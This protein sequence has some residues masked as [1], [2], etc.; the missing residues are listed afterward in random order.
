MERTCRS[1]PNCN[2]LKADEQGTV[3]CLL[4]VDK[5]EVVLVVRINYQFRNLAEG[6]HR[7]KQHA[8]DRLQSLARQF[9]RIQEVKVTVSAQRNWRTVDLTVDLGGALLR[10]EERS[11]EA[12]TSFDKALD[13]L[14]RQLQRFKERTRDF[15]RE[16]LRTLAAGEDPRKLLATEPTEEASDDREGVQIVR[17][18]IHPLKPMTPQEACLQMELLGHD[19]FV[20]VN[21][22]TQ[23]VGVVYRRR[24]GGYGLIEP[25]VSS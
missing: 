14:E 2:C 9:E 11:D 10:A 19:F 17:T 13:R 1:I 6:E 15:P 23:G 25:E 7:F 16:S 3:R 22:E 20:F 24:A 12:R 8:E 5:G 18:K 4:A 21:G